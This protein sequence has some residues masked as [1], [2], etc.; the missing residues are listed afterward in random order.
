MVGVEGF[1]IKHAIN[2]NELSKGQIEEI[3]MGTMKENMKELHEDLRIGLKEMGIQKDSAI[4]IAL[5]LKSEN[6]LLTMLDWIQKH[7]K[8]NPSENLVLAIAKKI[9]EKVQD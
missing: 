5:M 2:T 1:Q 8:E 6:Q 7:H 3:K 9:E 4:A